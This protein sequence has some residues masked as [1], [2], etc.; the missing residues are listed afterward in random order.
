MKLHAHA[1]ISWLAVVVLAGLAVSGCDHGTSLPAQ[2]PVA[3]GKNDTSVSCGMLIRNSPGPRAE[4]Y[5]EGRRQPL[6]FGSTR[7]FFAWI[8]QPEH[9]LRLQHLYVQDS[10]RIDWEHPVDA[11]ASFIDART[12]YYVAWQTLPGMM[13]PTFASFASR[14]KALAFTRAH[15]G[16][17]LRFADV[18]P[19]LAARLQL[20]CPLA[21][22]PASGLT[23]S[24]RA[25]P[26]T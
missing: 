22:S 19:E 8:L 18:T 14:D 3:I 16:E 9:R 21:G 13:G 6:K 23:K 10:A 12:A 5:L 7:D 2:P 24:C 20:T 26:P 11:A 17:V 25:A 4:A 1:G 15:G